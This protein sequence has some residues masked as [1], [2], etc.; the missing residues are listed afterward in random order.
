MCGSA[1]SVQA[2]IARELPAKSSAISDF[3]GSQ[4]I[5]KNS[6]KIPD[7]AVTIYAATTDSRT[8]R[9]ASD[10]VINMEVDWQAAL[11]QHDRWLRT[12]V[13]S[14]LRDREAVDEVMQEVALAVVRQ[15][16]P[17][18][19]ASKV[20]PWLYRLTVRQV[21]L[22]RRKC[23]RQ[24]KLLDQY[25][26]RIE[27]VV[28]RETDADPLDWLLASERREMVR[29]AVERLVP[30]DAE[31]LLLKYTENWSYDEIARHLGVSHAAVESRLHRARR[32]LRDELVVL[33]VVEV[34]K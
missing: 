30:L 27:S 1:H 34:R 33:E 5:V 6:R 15:A 18:R 11:A 14:R 26:K 8:L 3:D 7:R 23:G 2:P 4:K 22:F 12:V 28:E 13:Y 21:L 19:E 31:V 10:S 32:R 9:V 29:F 17:L 20:A 16:S 25:A 24:R